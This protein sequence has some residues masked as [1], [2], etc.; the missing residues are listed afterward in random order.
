MYFITLFAFIA[1]ILSPNRIFERT[2]PR[3]G[4]GNGKP[5]NWVD[6]AGYAA[7]GGELESENQIMEVTE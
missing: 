4:I 2:N 3:T 6:I 1:A 7:C 5:D